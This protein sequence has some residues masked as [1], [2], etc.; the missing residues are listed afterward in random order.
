VNV[1]Q[2]KESPTKFRITT[3]FVDESSAATISKY[4]YSIQ[5]L[6]T[7]KIVDT[8]ND[9]DKSIVYTFPEK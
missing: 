6:T 2:F 1:E 3:E 4:N 7:R 8:L 5:D 9:Q